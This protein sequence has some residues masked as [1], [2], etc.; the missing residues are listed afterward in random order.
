MQSSLFDEDYYRACASLSK[1]MTRSDLVEHYLK[2]WRKVQIDPLPTFSGHFYS[3]HYIKVA[4]KNTNPL[5]HYIS[6]GLAHSYY[7]NAL[8]LRMD[9]HIIKDSGVF[10]QD[11]Y[12]KSI[13]YENYLYNDPIYDYLL[14]GQYK[15][16]ISV[17]VDI[18]LSFIRRKY[19][20][21]VHDFYSPLSFY[22]RYKNK[23]WV[24]N[25]K[26]ELN[27]IAK[28]ITKSV[29]FNPLY[30]AT[31]ANIKLKNHNLAEHYA[32]LGLAKHFSCSKKFDTEYYLLAYPDIEKNGVNPLFH[33]ID[34][35]NEEGRNGK[36]LSLSNTHETGKK[37]DS[38]LKTILVVS[39]EASYTGAPIVALNI[40]KSLSKKYNIIAWLGK[41]G[42]LE[43]DF[44]HYS[45]AYIKGWGSI[46]EMK[47]KIYK[48]I[49]RYNV[50]LAIVNSVV[51]YPVIKPLKHQKV[52][53]VALIHE[54][55]DYVFP[56]GLL[57]RMA[58]FSDITVFPATLVKDAYLAELSMLGFYASSDNLYI[59]PQGYNEPK[60][61]KSYFTTSD[62]YSLLHANPDDKTLRIVFGAGWVQP[63]KGVDLFLQTAQQLLKNKQY[64][65][66]FIWVGGN[67]DPQKD[68][69]VSVFLQDHLNKSN[70]SRYV[71]MLDEQR[72]L[73]PFWRVT[74]IFFL[75]S[76]L[77]PFP[78]VVLD[79]LYKNIPVVCFKG[80]TGSADIA[81]S[82]PFAVR[83]VELSDTFAAAQAI[84][85]FARNLDKI[86]QQFTA[87]IGDKLHKTLSFESYIEALLDFAKEARKKQLITSHILSAV[88][89]IEPQ[90]LSEV[91]DTLPYFIKQEF[92]YKDRDKKLCLASL[93]NTVKLN[94]K[95]NPFG[96]LSRK[97]PTNKICH[98]G[99]CSIENKKEENRLH[100]IHFHTNNPEYILRLLGFITH[101]NRANIIVT[102]A[103]FSVVKALKPYRSS[104]FKLVDQYFPEAWSALK[105]VIQQCDTVY[106]SHCNFM[107]MDSVHNDKHRIRLSDLGFRFVFNLLTN[108]PIR[109]LVNNETISAVVLLPVFKSINPILDIG[110]QAEL[111][112]DPPDT[113][114][115]NFNGTYSLCS[116]RSFFSF[117]DSF[118]NINERDELKFYSM[119]FIYFCKRMSNSEPAIYP[120]LF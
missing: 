49:N 65:W 86:K 114:A 84:G 69:T 109:Y 39:H 27:S 2:Y 82:F 45:I 34:H 102:T 77:D 112:C 90:I 11:L 33:F 40:I 17:S 115:D 89:K 53:I 74:D 105:F 35:G 101:N 108:T 60:P 71:L 98:V 14:V 52:P 58:L 63:R 92:S 36:N 78:N 103:S 59:H 16:K 4:E 68:K 5:V 7:P 21:L 116:L 81:N 38:K 26:A 85:A 120:D 55:A 9:Y 57:S 23:A 64:N 10:N 97:Y 76:R 28:K 42:A 37:F 56:A 20:N 62:I 13:Q 48:L 67:Y 46:D 93:M 66:R 31:V 104:Q 95:I 47:L 72:S 12:L 22:L 51:S 1:R 30:Y 44:K 91:I 111:P 15:E 113:Y 79:A 54:F 83:A 61:Q 18:D 43:E 80:A 96:L 50:S 100:T 94:L 41:T 32:I 88:E 70:L 118:Y 106:L 19:Q 99:Y 75:S 119:L 73:E 110:V 25:S 87:A 117:A 107:F 6:R 8:L 24:Y 3:N 29:L